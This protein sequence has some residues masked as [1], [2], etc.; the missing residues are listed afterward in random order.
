MG[1]SEQSLP[2][3]RLPSLPSSPLHLGTLPLSSPPMRMLPLVSSPLH[4]L[5][6]LPGTLLSCHP[7]PLPPGSYSSFHFQLKCLLLQEGLLIVPRVGWVPSLRTLAASRAACIVCIFFLLC[8]INT[9]FIAL[10]SSPG[11][12]CGLYSRATTC[13]CHHHLCLN[14][15]HRRLPTLSTSSHALLSPAECLPKMWARS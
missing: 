9:C 8:T 4:K 1:P 11:L 10:L 5:F 15:S 6:P 2:P 14:D 13:L 7:N 3:A 12:A